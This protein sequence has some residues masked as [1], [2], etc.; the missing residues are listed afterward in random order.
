LLELVMAVL[1]ISAQ[2]CDVELQSNAPDRAERAPVGSGLT[3]GFAARQWGLV[4]G[5]RP[6]ATE[7]VDAPAN[8]SNYEEDLHWKPLS[9]PEGRSSATTG[10]GVDPNATPEAINMQ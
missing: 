9:S 10:P 5:S 4:S 7:E 2:G 8:S 6:Q 1:L 3:G